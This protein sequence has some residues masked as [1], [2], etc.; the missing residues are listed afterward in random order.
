MP[1]S[2]LQKLL[3]GARNTLLQVTNPIDVQAQRDDIIRELRPFNREDA[4]FPNTSADM[5]LPAPRP[6]R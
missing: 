1:G 4:V 5:P 2:I 3:D 6:R